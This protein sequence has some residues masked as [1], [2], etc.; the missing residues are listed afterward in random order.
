[1]QSQLA[2]DS[3]YDSILSRF[4]A[5]SSFENCEQCT[6]L[7]QFIS[8]ISV[9]R[10]LLDSFAQCEG[11]SNGPRGLRSMLSVRRSKLTKCFKDL[12]LSPEDFREKNATV[13]SLVFKSRF[14]PEIK[15]WLE[16]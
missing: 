12:G 1:M 14:G 5:A 13:G 4:V 2:I 7:L 6:K 16:E 10:R 15:E 11:R 3:V 8:V 9:I